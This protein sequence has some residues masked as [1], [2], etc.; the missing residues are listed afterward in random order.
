MVEA[1]DF[2]LG[3]NNFD[4]NGSISFGISEYIDIP[5]LKYAPEIGTLGLQVC[6]TLQRP[7]YRIKNRKTQ[8]KK[9]AQKHKINKDDAIKFMKE[10]YKVTMEAEE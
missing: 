2:V 4:Q 5:G 1:K 7:G 8:K 10:N 3:E 9:V 6:I